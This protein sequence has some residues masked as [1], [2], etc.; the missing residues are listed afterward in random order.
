MH[1]C[2]DH[3]DNLIL[4]LA[5]EVGAMLIVSNDTDLP[6]MSPRRG[7][8]ILTPAAFA[9]KVDAMRRHG[10][11]PCL[12]GH[13]RA[14]RFA[15]RAAPALAIRRAFAGAP[16]GAPRVLA[17]AAYPGQSWRVSMNTGICRVVLAWA[18]PSWG[19]CATSFGHSSARAVSSSSSAST[20]NVWVPTSALIVGWAL[21]L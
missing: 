19:Y 14:C 9:A 17:A 18:S 11:A 10:P 12:P 5:A 2:P 7:T 21:R 8:P 13:R 3:E 20:V 6:S 15:A 1:D 16:G 4:D